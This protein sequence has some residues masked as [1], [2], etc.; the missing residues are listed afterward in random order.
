M[1]GFGD[2]FTAFAKRLPTIRT[3]K[4]VQH[5][6]DLQNNVFPKHDLLHWSARGYSQY[7]A[8]GVIHKLFHDL[9]TT[10][11]Y[12]IEFGTQKD[13]V[14]CNTRRLRETCG[15]KGLL[16]DGDNENEEINLHAHFLTRE[17]ILLLFKRY[18]VPQFPDLLSVDID[19]NDYH[20]LSTILR[21]GYRPRVVIVEYNAQLG[22]ELDRIKNYEPTSTWKMDCYLSA[23]ITSYFTLAK[24]YN[25]SVVA[26]M[27]PDLYWVRNDVLAKAAQRASISKAAGGATESHRRG[28]HLY[29]HT[30]NKTALYHSALSDVY[31]NLVIGPNRDPKVMANCLA[32]GRGWVT[33]AQ[34][35][36]GIDLMRASVK[37]AA[38]ALDV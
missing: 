9:G 12:Y 32:A 1:P 10:N 29:A 6:P 37:E 3:D 21:G 19:G 22:V 24:H 18:R 4:C 25:Y 14:E 28:K 35:E 5:T 13:A 11:K 30:N 20:V 8:D 2:F 36:K 15:W 31:M 7:G 23:S 27:L 16:M 26:S 34:A 38:A 33:S 17:N